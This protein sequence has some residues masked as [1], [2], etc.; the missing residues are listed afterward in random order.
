[1]SHPFTHPTGRELLKRVAQQF[2]GTGTYFLRDSNIVFVCGGTG[3]DSMR[4]QFCEYA[5]TEIP[6]LRIF[7]AENAL[8]D[9]ITHAEPE[10]LNIGEF[11]DLIGE[12]SDCVVLFPES[13]GSF[14]ELG[15]FAKNHQLRKKLLVV[16]DLGLQGQDSFI[17]LG[18]INLIDNHSLFRPTIQIQYGEEP[19]FHLVKERI[20]RRISGRQRKRFQH[21]IYA[22]LELREKFFIIFEIINLFQ[23]ITFDGV[24]YAF[25]SIFKNVNKTQTIHLL[26]VLVAAQLVKR[27]GADSEFFYI[28][29]NARSFIE[30]E[31]LDIPAFRLEIVGFYKKNLPEI[32]EVVKGLSE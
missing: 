10:F 12:V 8:R 26:S 24:I 2:S 29:R 1:M 22:D 16:N 23:A 17:S 4:S 30:F 20:T 6:H 15:Y 28:D 13:P 27:R 31:N 3:D 14:A 32:A 11:E 9:Y 18:P 25:R 7:L 21:S 5:R 19:Q